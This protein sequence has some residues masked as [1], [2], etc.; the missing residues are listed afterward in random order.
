MK[1]FLALLLALTMLLSLTACNGQGDETSGSGDTSKTST[2]TSTSQTTSGSGGNTTLGGALSQAQMEAEILRR[3]SAIS[4]LK[5]LNLC[6]GENI[7]YTEDGIFWAGDYWTIEK[8]NM[9]KD[10]FT[11]SVEKQL[12]EAGFTADYGF[13]GTDYTVKA[14][15]GE[16]GINIWYDSDSSE[17]TLRM[18][19][20]RDEYSK[21]F[22]E[23]E[24]AKLPTVI[25]SIDIIDKLP[26]N[27]SVSFTTTVYNYTVCR[28]NGSYYVCHEL[29]DPGESGIK[30]TSYDV[31]VKND[32]G[33]YTYY[34][35]SDTLYIESGNFKEGKPQEYPNFMSQSSKTVEEVIQDICE[36]LSIWGRMCWDYKGLPVDSDRFF[37]D[38]ACS[39]YSISENM[40]KVGAET[41]L[42]RNCEKVHSE[43]LWAD[44]YDIIYDLETGMV[45]KMTVSKNDTDEFETIVEVTEYNPN[46]TSLGTF[47]QP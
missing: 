11:A 20:K 14:G 12:T 33:T 19:N 16:I 39:D 31:A 21:A 38:K 34:D 3:L 41:F 10:D 47:V 28:Y 23:T 2:S 32:D 1:K 17:L 35:W 13:M 7:T 45:M 46:P 22:I 5:A 4:D 42:G 37:W 26:E 40:T 6:S 25:E 43:G 29:L 30:F 36:E 24:N 18:T 27:F 9:S 8:P 15:T 44:S